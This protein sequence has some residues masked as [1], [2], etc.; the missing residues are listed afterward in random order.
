[1]KVWKHKSKG[2]KGKGFKGKVKGG[3]PVSEICGDPRHWRDQCPQN[4]HFKKIAS[5]KVKD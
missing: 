4:P 2:F 3:P 5:L 1:M